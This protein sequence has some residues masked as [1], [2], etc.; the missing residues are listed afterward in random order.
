RHHTAAS[1]GGIRAVSAAHNPAWRALGR[2]TVFSRTNP[3]STLHCSCHL[4]LYHAFPQVP[5][6]ARRAFKLSRLLSERHREGRP[7]YANI[8]LSTLPSRATFQ[9]W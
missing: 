5:A 4:K 2:G 9:G 1:A 8:A 7:L 6:V 3:N